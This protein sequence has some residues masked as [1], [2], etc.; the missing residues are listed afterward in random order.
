MISLAVK[1][2][3]KKLL[4]L[5]DISYDS[6]DRLMRSIMKKRDVTA[7]EL[8]YGFVDKHNCT[9]DEWVRKQMK[10][11]DLQEGKG[12]DILNGAEISTRRVSPRKKITLPDAERHSP[13][14]TKL[15]KKELAKVSLPIIPK[16]Q[17]NNNYISLVDKILSEIQEECNNSCKGESCPCHGVAACPTKKVKS[18]GQIAK[19]HKVSE[20]DIET[21]LK[22]GVKVEHE[23]T[24]N[25]KLAREIALQH[26]EEK[27]DYYTRL[28][29]ME[30][31]AKKE[32]KKFKDVNEGFLDKLRGRKQVGTTGSGGKVYVST[33]KKPS[34]L[35][36]ETNPDEEQAKV[37]IKIKKEVDSGQYSDPWLKSAPHAERKQHYRQLRGESV[38]EKRYCPLCDK[39]ESRSE[40]SYGEKAWDKVSVK[41]E[42]YSM[43]R[44]ELSTMADAIKRLQMK[45][46]KGEG[47]LEAWVQSKITKASDYIDTAA[48]YVAGGEMDEAC[49][50]G[51]KQVGMKK[52]GKKSVPNCVPVS[53]NQL[54]NQILDEL[55][56]ASKSGDSSLHD[57]FSKSKSN[58]DTPG[59]VQIG[60]PFAGA[61]CARQP[62]QRS[63]PK[64]GS[65][66]MAA[67]LTDKEEERAFRRKN[68]KD[69]DQPE[70]SNGAK[71]TYVKTE[72]VNLEEEKDAC[73]H[74]V[75]SRYK[76]WPSAYACVPEKT[77]KA[78]CKDGWKTVNEL[79][80]GDEILTYNMEKDILEFKPVSNIHRY[81]KVKTKVL[82]SGNTGFVFESTDNHKWVVKLP[83][84][85]STRISK[86]N[87]INNMT[88]IETG[89]LLKSKS[90]KHLVVAAQYNSGQPTKKNFL[91]KYGDNWIEYILSI[92]PEQRQ[93]W[94]F[95]A[96]V[97]DGNQKRVER[98]TEQRDGVSD[99]DYIYTSPNGNQSFGFKQKNIEHR[100]AF[101]LA[102]FLNGGTVTWKEHSTNPIYCCHYVSNKR[103][104]NTSNL[105][106]IEENIADVWCPETENN[107][108]VMM[109][110]TNGCGIITITGNSGALVK[111][112]KVGADNWGEKTKE[113]VDEAVKLPSEYGNVLSIIIS[114]RGRTIMSQM[115]FPQIRVPNKK[116]IEF[117]VGKVYP[118]AR[119]ISYKLSQYD[120][121]QPIIQ[122]SNSRS[123]NY[124][125][126]NKT[127]GEEVE[128]G[129][130]YRTPDGPKKFAVKVKNE[131]GNIITVR[132][133]DPNME[134]KRDDPERLKSFRARHNCEDPGPRTKARYWSCYQWRK[135]HKV[136]D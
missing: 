61:P 31:S 84:S 9:P 133:G 33:R 3:E 108:W 21:Q 18:I 122:I 123:R 131:K 7:K 85:K 58:D 43:V 6:I 116:Q 81:Q 101:L 76:V 125:L 105:R 34:N 93:T 120:V 55:I 71:P 91:Y 95:S 74:K 97:Y 2:L 62:G 8:H 37:D 46:G 54:V 75:K 135:G 52:K 103:Y 118:E 20:E 15:V 112:R 24:N 66:K 11:K 109:Q 98:L 94:L 47:N 124:L 99:L 19:K 72:E 5:D 90:N 50:S 104:K 44:S 27:P 117:E 17:L 65:S 136:E 73:Y 25:K 23:H 59:W 86:Y 107:T 67:D 63:T 130:P 22:M 77:S 132:F 96:I 127:I 26:L 48:D 119:V 121:N 70:K 129:K 68:R 29:K 89:N 64:C 1:E 45:V 128:L 88:L 83:E 38:E 42:E 110:E 40:C 102:A 30:A 56:E 53:E 36:Y 82:Q 4:K 114:W 126:N 78:L 41:D 134:I 92:S 13:E 60:G 115:F 35:K 80:L 39:R 79:N 111:C 69:P 32:H 113:S 28:K 12:S 49:W 51:Y 87:K 14:A 57:W 10:N 16:K 100:D 106:L